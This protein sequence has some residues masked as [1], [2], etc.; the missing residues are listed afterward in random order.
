MC[1]GYVGVPPPL[2][3]RAKGSPSVAT[4][5][6]MAQ[7]PHVRGYPGLWTKFGHRDPR[8]GSVLGWYLRVGLD[9]D[10]VFGDEA[11]AAIQLSFVPVLV[12]F[13]VEDLGR[14]RSRE[15]SAW[16]TSPMQILAPPM[17]QLSR[18]TP[19]I[20]GSDQG[21]DILPKTWCGVW[22]LAHHWAAWHH[23]KPPARERG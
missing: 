6:S 15:A 11:L 3:A 14:E 2:V 18:D 20:R 5:L 13:H 9:L 12:I 22:G 17:G 21:S 8:L 23:P 19:K 16:P 4:H 7:F 10:V 1:L